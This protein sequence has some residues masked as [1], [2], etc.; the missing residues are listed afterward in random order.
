VIPICNHSAYVEECLNSLVAAEYAPLEVLLMDDGSRDNSY[1]LAESWRACRPDAFFR[2]KLMRQQNQGAA[3]SCNALIRLSTGAYIAPLASDDCLLPRGLTAR[4]QY[5]EQNPGLL[6]VMG[7]C[8]IISERSEKISDSALFDYRKSDRR[9]FTSPES[10]ADELVLRWTVPGPVLLL[11]REAFFGPRA[12][13]FYAEDDGIEDRDFFLRLLHRNALGFV[14]ERVSAYRVHIANN[15][16]P[17]TPT[18]RLAHYRARLVSERKHIELF[19]GRRR[20]FLR[21]ASMRFA[22]LVERLGKGSQVSRL[23]EFVAAA[24]MVMLYYAT[25]I[26]RRLSFG[27][28]WKSSTSGPKTS[29]HRTI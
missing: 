14:P 2:F 25:W 22:C 18:G 15:C 7:D 23:G 10:L 27:A 17:N 19:Q 9:A 1:E 8:T 24:G 28:R 26:G 13:G 12:I 4:V 3:R 29:V 11:R 5:L 6:A 20:L 21:L 16:R